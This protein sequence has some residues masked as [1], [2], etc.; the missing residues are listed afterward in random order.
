MQSLALAEDPDVCDLHDEY[1]L[2]LA[3]ALQPIV[4]VVRQ[5]PRLRARL[6]WKEGADQCMEVLEKVASHHPASKRTWLE[7][8]EPADFATT[9]F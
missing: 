5:S 4:A 6:D 1:F 2:K 7:T 8:F 9:A 3:R